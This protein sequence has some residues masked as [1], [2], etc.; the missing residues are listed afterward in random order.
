L[1]TDPS[2]RPLFFGAGEICSTL[3]SIFSVVIISIENIS[4]NKYLDIL[5]T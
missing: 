5:F 1:Q 4:L 3:L 2:G